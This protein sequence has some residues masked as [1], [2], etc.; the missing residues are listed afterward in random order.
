MSHW[1][2]SPGTGQQSND[3]MVNIRFIMLVN[4]KLNGKNDFF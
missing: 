4:L 3:L 1:N 2:D